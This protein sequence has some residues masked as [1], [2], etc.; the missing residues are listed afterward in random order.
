[1]TGSRDC[2]PRRS[3]PTSDGI[4][5]AR[6]PWPTSALEPGSEFEDA[7]DDDLNISQALGVLFETIRET[8]RALDTGQ[9][10]LLP[11][12][13][14]WLQWWQRID[15]VLGVS[16]RGKQRPREIA[17]LAEARIQAR[18]A[19]DWR[20]SDELRDQLAALGW[21]VRDTKDGHKITRRGGA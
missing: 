18:L 9:H 10:G 2:K 14:S 21:E 11:T 19:K 7:L 20:K 15:Q 4:T 8:N 12:A 6:P 1:M 3:E 5:S 16:R 17:E 13:D